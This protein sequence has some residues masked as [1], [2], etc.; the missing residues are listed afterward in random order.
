MKLAKS[1]L[2]GSAAGLATVAA[3]Q[4]ADLPTRKAAPVEYV[5]VC[6]AYG[7]GF[8]YI[9]GTDT[10]LRV[11]G[12]VLAQTHVQTTLYSVGLPGVGGA[13]PL[14]PAA[15]STALGLPAAA[16]VM[17]G[18]NAYKPGN[19]N[20]R[21]LQRFDAAARV[22]LDARTQS[23]FGTVRTFVRLVGQ[24]GSGANSTT[25]SVQ[26]QF[27]GSSLGLFN[28]TAYPTTAKELVYLDKAFIQFAGITAGRVQSFFD[29]YADAINYESL[30]GSNNNVWALAYTATFGGGFSAT[31]AMEDPTSHRAG[32][33]TVVG[34]AGIGMPGGIISPG[35]AGLIT[36]TGFS[37]Q[38]AATRIPDIIG[39]VRIDQPW[40][41]VQLAAA[42]HPVRAALFPA[43]AAA[44]G[45][46]STAYAFTPV[47]SSS[48]GY[49]I[50]GGVQL[51]LDN[52]FGPGL[53]SAG[54]KL[55]LQATYA[56]GGFGYVS[57]ADMAFVSGP[58]T[59]ANYGIGLARSSNAFGYSGSDVDCTFTY[60]GRC[61]KS[62]EFALVA[63]L[64]H[65]WTPTISSGLFGSYLQVDYSAAA[66]TPVNLVGTFN[67]GQTNYKEGRLGTNLVWTPIK[68]FDIGTEIT[69]IRSVTSRPFGLAPDYV[70]TAAGL[71]AFRST[72]DAF[73]GKLR[74]IRAF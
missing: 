20:T 25:G 24:Y 63:A 4:A 19:G 42:L 23:P 44:F 12:L 7:A 36:S 45:T 73:Y 28:N 35:S 48:F 15:Y 16:G 68:N 2:L 61:E 21:D 32:V 50:Q 34:A 13:L 67:V 71:P 41:A 8:F 74:A 65:Y 14:A 69:W 39:N 33:N 46:A 17:P 59:T 38:T 56:K 3:A 30:R 54:D 27:G 49:A 29:F 70:L 11:G 43:S 18:A 22:E 51:N 47:S 72:V 60:T 31:I 6:D 64:K 58:N 1:L 40:G 37:A 53:F 9:P 57:G 52:V 66:R 62:R 26:S 55:W 5:R 10:C